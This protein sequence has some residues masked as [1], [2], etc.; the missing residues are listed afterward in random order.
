MV[1]AVVIKNITNVI[2]PT[3]D[4]FAAFRTASSLAGAG[5][6][7]V[8]ES[9]EVESEEVESEEAPPHPIPVSATRRPPVV[10]LHTSSIKLY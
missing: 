1:A 6:V 4:L 7:L 5:D 3:D 10:F 9:E 8:V 2:Y